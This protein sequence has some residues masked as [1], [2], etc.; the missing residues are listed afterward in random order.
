M[1][2]AWYLA[3]VSRLSYRI[4]DNPSRSEIL[5]DGQLEKVKVITSKSNRCII[6]RSTQKDNPFYVVVFRGSANIRNWITNMSATMT[7][8]P[9]YG[10]V[11]QGFWSTMNTLSDAME[12][13]LDDVDTSI[14]YTGHSLGGAIAILMSIK[15]MPYAVYTLGSLRVGNQDFAEA[16]R[17]FPIYRLINHLDVV[18]TLPIVDPVYKYQ[19]TGKQIYFENED[20]NP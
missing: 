5:A 19:S 6:L 17:E 15:N 7:T 16:T 20:L 14:Y 3:E 4:V 12:R 9:G 13:E 1:I 8:V 2:N 10:K 18:P 11:H